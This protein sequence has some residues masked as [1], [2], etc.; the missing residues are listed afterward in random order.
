M[1]GIDEHEPL[2][3]AAPLDRRLNLLCDVEVST[4]RLR[5]EP[6]LFTIG[7]HGRRSVGVHS[8]E[9]ETQ[10]ASCTISPGQAVNELL[11][12]YNSTMS[13][14]NMTMPSCPPK[15]PR[16]H[17][18]AHANVILRGRYLAKNTAGTIVETPAQLF[19]RVATDIARAERLYPTAG[20]LPHAAQRWYECMAR[21]DFL[22][23][24]P[25]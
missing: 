19:W 6:E 15:R 12:V 10:D 4:P 22:P 23:T 2:S 11:P 3:D 5:L 13:V 8:A 24:S 18:S 17:L 14:K 16:L 9:L 21:L 1:H 7:F 20:R 25:T